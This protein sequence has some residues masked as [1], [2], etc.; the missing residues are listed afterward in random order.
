MSSITCC[1]KKL[2]FVFALLALA[3]VVLQA[4]P[5]SAGG[6]CSTEGAGAGNCLQNE[7]CAAGVTQKL[8]CTANDVRVAKVIN[9]RNPDGSPINSCIAGQTGINFVADFLVQT[10]STSSRS[11]IGLYFSEF[12]VTQQPTALTGTC[13]DNVIS[14]PHHVTG[15]SA[16]LGSGAYNDAACTGFGTYDELDANEPK[17][18]TGTTGCGDSTSG[19]G[20][21]C[22]TA[23]D[24]LGNA[25]AVPCSSPL[26]AQ[27][28]TATQVVTVEIKNFTC[29]NVAAG[30]QVQLPNCTSWQIPGGTIMC[31]TGPTDYPYPTA[32]PT[33][34]PGT[35]SKCNCGVVALPIIVQTP[36][37]Q[38]Q[39]ACTTTST[40][41]PATFDTVKDTES[42][43]SCDAGPEGT[44]A[45]TYTVELTN[46]SNTGGFT[47]DQICDDRFGTIYRSGSAPVSLA[48]CGAGT[49]FLGNGTN[50]CT[51]TY[52]LA[53]NASTSCTFLSTPNTENLPQTSPTFTDTITAFGHGDLATTKE[54]S[55]TSDTVSVYSE[56]APS[57]AKTTPTPTTTTKICVTER[58]TAVVQNTSAAD[59]NI[60]LH[61]L[62][63][64]TEDL[65]ALSADIVGTTCGQ[66]AGGFGLGT[67]NTTA[68]TA[69]NGG[70]FPSPAGFS[71]AAGTGNPVTNG[72]TYTC[73]FD[74]L[75]CGAPG[76]AEEFGTGTCSPA[77]HTCSAGNVGASCSTDAGCDSTCTGIS[78][79]D[80]L[81]ANLTGD[82]ASPADTISPVTN[83]TSSFTQCLTEPPFTTLQ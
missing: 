71:L 12:D 58:F 24:N 38:V 6:I 36:S 22:L 81:S 65:T 1:C 13:S 67:L 68:V 79:T 49:T 30:T 4:T 82:D 63:D 33:A 77:T 56:D 23:N 70:V 66:A 10:S 20:T 17:S 45:V 16:C 57:S 18:T 34:I 32:P 62:S 40:P 46:T 76:P 83:K 8:N 72:G 19:D 48:P 41:G 80:T 61:G 74:V 64:N 28:F 42:P 52:D 44:E 27:T 11:N 60:N 9:T 15:V 50:N 14:P 78:H 21:V 47:V 59:E 29:P 55:G 37:V 43:T 54:V 69:S 25:T 5:A 7:S 75:F 26:A 31:T 3:V 73:L 35:P 51:G 2:S 39:K 53:A